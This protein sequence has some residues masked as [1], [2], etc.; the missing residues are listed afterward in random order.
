MA[1]TDMGLCEDNSPQD[2]SLFSLALSQGIDH[3]NNM[4]L[5]SSNAEIKITLE[6]S[7]LF[8]ADRQTITQTEASDGQPTP[9]FF[10]TANTQRCNNVTDVITRQTQRE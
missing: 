6:N 5:R 9:T 4:T 8:S 3:C 10:P 7:E 2:M 1:T